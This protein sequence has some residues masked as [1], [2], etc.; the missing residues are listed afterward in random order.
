M[1]MDYCCSHK[2]YV[3]KSLKKWPGLVALCEKRFFNIYYKGKRKETNLLL[4]THHIPQNGLWLR[5]STLCV[6]S[7]HTPTCINWKNQTKG[8]NH[9]P[10]ITPLSPC[11]WWHLSPSSIKK[12]YPGRF[13]CVLYRF[14]NCHYLYDIFLRAGI[15]GFCKF[16][17]EDI[18]VKTP[19]SICTAASSTS[20]HWTV[21]REDYLSILIMH[22]G[23]YN[24]ISVWNVCV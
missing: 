10:E 12:I 18:Q 20:K 2:G 23:F 5:R 15:T 9:L 16:F 11:D 4:I 7:I 17:S 8:I 3:V 19:F 13:T 6:L 1:D 24:N 14:W 22:C 21:H